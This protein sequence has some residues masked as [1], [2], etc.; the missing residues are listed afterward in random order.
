MGFGTTISCERGVICDTYVLFDLAI[1]FL[2]NADSSVAVF[3]F[4]T[5]D[6]LELVSLSP[7][8]SSATLSC[9]STVPLWFRLCLQHRYLS[10]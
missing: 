5:S 7:I 2:S 4:G 10:C 3:A 8:S 9:F 6:L 1:S